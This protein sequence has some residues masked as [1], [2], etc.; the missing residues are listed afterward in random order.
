MIEKLGFRG[1]QSFGLEQSIELRPLTLLFGPNSSGKSSV[2]RLL[3]MLK[4]SANGPGGIQYVGSEVDLGSFPEVLFRK[5]AAT[6]ANLKIDLQMS[7]PKTEVEVRLRARAG[8]SSRLQTRAIIGPCS[9]SMV[10]DSENTDFPR[11]LAITQSLIGDLNDGKVQIEFDLSEETISLSSMMFF[12]L[13]WLSQ[14][15]LVGSIPNGHNLAHD[16]SKL[17]FKDADQ[18][19]NVIT[20]FEEV[21]SHFKFEL[22]I[23]GFNRGGPHIIPRVKSFGP[24]GPLLIHQFIDEL[25]LRSADLLNEN[26]SRF[27]YF[28]PLRQVSAQYVPPAGRSVQVAPDASNIQEHLVSI[29]DSRFDVL[30]HDLFKLTNE[31]FSLVKEE[32]PSGVTGIA[33][34]QQVFLLDHNSDTRVS[35]A[36]SGTGLS[37]V[38]PLMA[39]L[40]AM[41]GNRSPKPRGNTRINFRSEVSR[42]AG[43]VFIEQPELHLHPAMQ[44]E[45]GDYLLENTAEPQEPGQVG[46]DKPFVICE[47]HSEAMLMRI[48]RRIREGK[49]LPDKVAIYCVDRMPASNSSYLSMR[50]LTEQGSYTLPW[51]LSFASVRAQED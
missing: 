44:A 2:G 12:D 15:L 31:N 6:E 21:L 36:N 14:D 22:R 18:P 42:G 17:E 29:E 27:Q 48:E 19:N 16:P 32:V 30:S 7:R 8:R 23:G 51:P 33:G 13:D 25:L 43:M 4:Q 26:L 35:F 46:G 40:M 37:Q 38:L 45:L 28:G 10:F 24:W 5:A 9:M 34:R 47:T 1:F 11:S 39:G 49:Y 3:R 50:E 20:S 41:G